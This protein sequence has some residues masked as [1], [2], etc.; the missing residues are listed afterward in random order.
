[1]NHVKVVFANTDATVV[2]VAAIT[3]SVVDDA[4]TRACAQSGNSASSG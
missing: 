1:M 4:F 2:V 3:A